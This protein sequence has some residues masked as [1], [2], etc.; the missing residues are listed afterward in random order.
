MYKTIAAN[1][2]IIQCTYPFFCE[3]KLTFPSSVSAFPF[4]VQVEK[5]AMY[6]MYIIYHYSK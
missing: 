2:V 4:C 1:Y 3:Y 5:G 6:Y